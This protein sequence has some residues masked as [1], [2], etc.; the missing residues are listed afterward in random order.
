MNNIC[1][2]CGY[3]ELEVPA[4]RGVYGEPSYDIC[5][6]CWYQYGKTDDDE[7]ISHEEWRERWIAEG[8]PWRWQ[9]AP[10]PLDGIPASS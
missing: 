4:Y 3:P 7:G 6:S 9:G 10:P 1:P 2:V 5:S 8:M